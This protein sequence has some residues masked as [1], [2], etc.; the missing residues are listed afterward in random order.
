LWRTLRP[1]GRYKERTGQTGQKR[2]T[3]DGEHANPHGIF[4]RQPF[5]LTQRSPWDRD[6]GVRYSSSRR[7]VSAARLSG[8]PAPHERGRHIRRAAS[9]RHEAGA[10]TA[11]P[12]GTASSPK[13][14]GPNA[15]VR[16]VWRFFPASGPGGRQFQRRIAVRHSSSGW[17]FA[18]GGWNRDGAR[19]VAG[20]PG[21][22]CSQSRHR[23]EFSLGQHYRRMRFPPI[24]WVSAET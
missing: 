14:A 23:R 1:L 8:P 20:V 9:G 21:R 17:P 2:S 11:P 24:L 15:G 19:N 16:G 4:Y 10:S 18:A 5:Y 7:P 22:R 13:A 6:D 3:I 12:R